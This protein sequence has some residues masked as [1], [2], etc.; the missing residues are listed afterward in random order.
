MIIARL[1]AIYVHGLILLTVIYW[2]NQVGCSDF[3]Q[4]CLVTT[5][6]DQLLGQGVCLSP[7]CTDFCSIVR[8]FLYTSVTFLGLGIQ[9]FFPPIMRKV[10]DIT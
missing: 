8:K 6:N 7:L 3:A 9:S 5:P 10:D 4:L 2:P 1:F